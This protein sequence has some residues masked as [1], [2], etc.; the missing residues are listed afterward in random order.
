MDFTI[1]ADIEVMLERDGKLV[2]AV[3]V[4]PAQD[5]GREL[6][7]G[8][9][10]HDNVLA[11]FNV[12]PARSKEGFVNNVLEN[13]AATV[14]LLR[15]EQIGL[16]IVSSAHYPDSELQTEAAKEFG[17]SPDFCA[18]K[19]DQN[20][21]EWT[22]DQTT[23]RTAGAHIHFG[24]EIFID[25]FKVVDMVKLMD[26]FIGIPSV[27]RDNGP[28]A[29]ERRTLYGKAGAHRAKAYPGGEYRP[30]S[31]WWVRD[32]STIE[33]VYDRTASCL[34]RLLAGDTLESLGFDPEV[35]QDVINNGNETAAAEINEKV[36][37][38]FNA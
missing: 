8:V 12:D 10:F 31:N 1:G 18:Y 9:I 30:M 34:K 15:P 24:H 5:H 3:P 29:V 17:C 16:R 35:I 7:Y 38:L 33:W 6:P 20:I 36:E 2:S 37:A 11:E 32:R 25:P 27:L 21:V 28:E 26:V 13:V 22:A 19:I 14:E 4:L 23:L